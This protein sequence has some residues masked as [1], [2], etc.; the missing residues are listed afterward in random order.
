MHLSCTDC[1]ITAKQQHSTRCCLKSLPCTTDTAIQ[2]RLH[3]NHVRLHMLLPSNATTMSYGTVAATCNT[4]MPK[5]TTV[6]HTPLTT[7]DN[8]GSA[9]CD[10]PST[11][12]CRR[13]NYPP[14]RWPRLSATNSNTTRNPDSEACIGTN[15]VLNASCSCASTYPDAHQSPAPEK[16]QTG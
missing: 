4:N 6:P 14:P 5:S 15:Q 9:K 16:P 10:L 1:S 7:S 3:N 13:P 8:L 12:P 11:P 2:L